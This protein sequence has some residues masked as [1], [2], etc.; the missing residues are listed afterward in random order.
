M[1]TGFEGFIWLVG[2]DFCEKKMKG[3]FWHKAEKNERV[4]KLVFSDFL[5]DW[6]PL[7]SLTPLIFIDGEI[8]G[9]YST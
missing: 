5:N 2:K 1:Q 4:E 9:L 3:T 8:L 7:V 6:L